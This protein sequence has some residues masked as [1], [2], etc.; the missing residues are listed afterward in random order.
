MW[1]RLLIHTLT[2]EYFVAAEGASFI[3]PSAD[4][5]ATL[6]GTFVLDRA[7]RELGRELNRGDDFVGI[8]LAA[9]A[10]QLDASRL[11]AASSS[12]QPVR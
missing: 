4:D 3:P 12:P 11:D 7:L 5:R 8:P 1:K 2:A 6:L 9:V 10:E